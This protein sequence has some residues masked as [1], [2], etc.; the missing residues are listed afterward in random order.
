[1]SSLLRLDGRPTAGRAHS[2]WFATCV[3]LL[4]SAHGRRR[5]RLTLWLVAALVYV[6]SGLVLWFGMQQGWMYAGRLLPWCAFLAGAL[7]LVYVALRSGWSERFQ[8]PALT[9]VQM[10][11]GII[12][13]DWGYAIC[14]PV[15]S[16]AL[17]PLLLIFTFG[18][19]SLSWRKI[20]ALTAFALASLLGTVIAL[21][22]SRGSADPWSLAHPSLRLD[23]A[24]VLMISIMLPALSFVAAILSRLR[25]RLSSQRAELTEAL[26]E[27]QRI[28]TH[29]SLTGLSN[30]RY[31]DQ[32]LVEEQA[33]AERLERPFSIGLIDLDHFK[34][35]NDLSGHAGGDQV[36]R[37]FADQARHA[38]RSCDQIARW[39]GEE[40]L[41]L[42][43]GTVGRQ[44]LA[45][46]ERLLEQLHV[47][48]E[49]VVAQLSFSAG[50]TEYLNGETLADM[51]ARADRE[52]Y[53]AKG[54]GRNNVRLG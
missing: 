21:H 49:G 52:M 28:A 50:V 34:R 51:I 42:M 2:R 26:L 30:R 9:A 35:I 38:M 40:F 25:A 14:G 24:N 32:R 3:D 48:Q 16:M 13:V 4:L 29:D 45:C 11:I 10:V 8:D 22:A 36:L 1:M 41:V 18:A 54:A 44:A 37:W 5:T 6:A 43:P 46:V 27:V 47:V 31:M 33:I 19:F 17:F 7:A 20:A 23:L 39:G 53:A 12:G 15:R